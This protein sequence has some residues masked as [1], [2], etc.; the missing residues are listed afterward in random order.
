LSDL[1]GIGT[2]L[3]YYGILNNRQVSEIF[4]KKKEKE[5]KKTGDSVFKRQNMQL[6][7]YQGP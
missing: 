7:N 3:R 5:R 1:G 4:N 6:F 2:L